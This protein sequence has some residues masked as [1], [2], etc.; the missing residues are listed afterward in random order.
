VQKIINNELLGWNL[1][2]NIMRMMKSRKI[3]WAGHV[4]RTGERCIREFWWGLER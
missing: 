2:P 3:R 4:A 1:S